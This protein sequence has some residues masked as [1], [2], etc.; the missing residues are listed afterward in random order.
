V[1]EI[2]YDPDC[3]ISQSYLAG[4]ILF[5]LC[6][7]GFKEIDPGPRCM[8]RVFERPR[9]EDGTI[10]VVVFTSIHKVDGLV[11]D[12][13]H[14]AIRV[15]LVRRTKD[16]TDRGLVKAKRVNRV[17]LIG[18]ICDRM[19]DRMRDCWRALAEVEKCDDC[20]APMFITKKNKSCCSELCFRDKPGYKAKSN[21][22]ASS[23]KKGRRPSRRY[24]GATR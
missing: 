14:D 3:S 12:K 5:R 18:A 16:G 4:E 19:R 10:R 7:C 2:K 23:Y 13:G 11:R 21:Y 17:G 6:E 24:Y 22:K 1:S 20:G 9:N 15:C 8:E